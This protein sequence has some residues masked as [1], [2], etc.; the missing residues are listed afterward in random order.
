[1]MTVLGQVIEAG[2]ENGARQIFDVFDTLLVTVSPTLRLWKTIL[3]LYR[4]RP[5][6]CR[7]MCRSWF[8]FYFSVSGTEPF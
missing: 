4:R 1:M 6:S 2:D 3:I 8:N 7:S 5:P